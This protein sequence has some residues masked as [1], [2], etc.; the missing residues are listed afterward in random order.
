MDSI[1]SLSVRLCLYGALFGLLWVTG[2][3]PALLG[4]LFTLAQAWL[5][6]LLA[7]VAISIATFIFRFFIPR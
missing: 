1:K 5:F 6:L 7:P 4:L 2:V 3:I